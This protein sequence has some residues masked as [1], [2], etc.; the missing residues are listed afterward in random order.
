MTLT[1]DPATRIAEFRRTLARA[2][3]A[4][5][6]LPPHG[7][8]DG[9]GLK[10]RHWSKCIGGCKG[11]GE[12]AAFE[13]FRQVCECMTA[14]PPIATCW[15][16]AWEKHADNCENCN[17]LCWQ[18]RAGGMADA[19]AGVTRR[20]AAEVYRQLDPMCEVTAEGPYANDPMPD[21][22]TILAQAL[23]LV[24][25]IKELEVAK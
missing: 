7:Q 12:V 15:R 8:V 22:D 14:R 2:T 3:K 10:F 24:C 4:C 23:E 13:G 6:E 5:P 25:E 18:V 17:G 9:V 19:L 16:C 11:T 21:P 20:E 1:T